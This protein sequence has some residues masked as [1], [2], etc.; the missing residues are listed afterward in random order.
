V[1]ESFET[2]VLRYFNVFGPRQN[3]F[4]QYAAVV[5]L[6]VTRSRRQADLRARRRRAVARLHLRRNVVDATILAADAA[7]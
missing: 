6:F 4:S 1:Y 3:P 5:P 2:V 7:S